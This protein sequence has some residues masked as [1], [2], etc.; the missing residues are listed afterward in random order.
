MPLGIEKA[1][2]LAGGE[3]TRLRPLTYEIAKPLVP[4]KGK[5]VLQWNIEL[6]R[7]FGAKEIVIFVYSSFCLF[8]CFTLSKSASSLRIVV[9]CKCSITAK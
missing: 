9:N 4:V 5:P 6:C 3:G 2:I 1:F 7:L 8:M